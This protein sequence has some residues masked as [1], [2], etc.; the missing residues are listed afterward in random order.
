MKKVF[1]GGTCNNSTWRDEL[2]SL[3]KI[4]Y[5]NPIVDNWTE[6]SKKEE[7]R[8][9]IICDYEVYVITPK[10]KGV[11]SIAEVIESVIKKGNNV[12][13]CYLHNDAGDF[14]DKQQLNSLSEVGNMVLKYGG[15]VLTSMSDIANY[16]NGVVN[17]IS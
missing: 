11:Y 3:L 5:F 14:F 8:Q 1:L 17:V 16:F 9:K 12:V 15:V 13:F 10:M 7:M 4:P 6:E 2:I